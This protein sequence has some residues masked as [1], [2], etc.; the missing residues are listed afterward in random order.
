M[1]DQKFSI[2]VEVDASRAAAGLNQAKTAAQQTAQVFRTTSVEAKKI[3][4]AMNGPSFANKNFLT[5]AQG[6]HLR[7]QARAM[8]DMTSAVGA[9]GSAFKS[10]NGVDLSGG[11]QKA[12][13]AFR[14]MSQAMKAVP[15]MSDGMR[16]ALSEQVAVMKEYAA[17]SKTIAST[18][19][20]LGKAASAPAAIAAGTRATS[21]GLQEQAAAAT[22]A[23]AQ[24]QRYTG[25]LVDSL[26][27]MQ[28]VRNTLTALAASFGAYSVAVIGAAA[29]QERAFADVDRVLSAGSGTSRA[30]IEGLK[31]EY[32]QMATEFSTSFEDLTKI[33]T[34]G[35]QMNIAESDLKDFTQAVAEFAVVTGVSVDES[36][37]KM[38]RLVQFFNQAK[39]NDAGYQIRGA[40]D[41]SQYRQLASQIAEL[42]ASAV[43]TE[44]DILKMSE[45]IVTSTSNAGIGQDATLAYATT[46]TSTGIQAENARGAFQRLFKGFNSA[47][48]EGAIGMSDLAEQLNI[49]SEAAV[50]LW[51][52]D[53]NEFFMRLLKSLHEMDSISRSTAL[54][55]LGIKN[56]R[57]V[58]VVARL[59]QNYDLL[60]NSMSKAQSAGQDTS[61]LDESISII[62]STLTETI[63]RAK[64][65]L[66]NLGASLGEPFLN[67]IKS[68]L[69]AFTQAVQWVSTAFD[70]SWGRVV[71]S[72]A[73]GVTMA[74]ALRLGMAALKAAVVA[75]GHAFLNMKTTV[76][77]MGLSTKASW[78][79]IIGLLRTA[80]AETNNL[81]ATT[82]RLAP[83]TAKAANIQRSLE[84]A[85]S[86]GAASSAAS[87]ASSAAAG[88]SSAAA[89]AERATAALSRTSAAA[90]GA[91]TSMGLLGRASGAVGGVLS[92]IA[93]MGPWGWVTVGI[94]ALSAAIPLIQEYADANKHAAEEA[95]NRAKE[96]AS[97]L[98]SA[99]DVQKAIL[100]DA[101]A[102]AETGEGT[103]VKIPVEGFD[104][105]DSA[106]QKSGEVMYW[107]I[108]ASGQMVQ[109]TEKQAEA[110]GLAATAIGDNTKQLMLNAVQNSEA[111]KELSAKQRDWLTSGDFDLK[112]YFNAAAQGTDAADEFLNAYR[113]KLD[114]ELAATQ[115]TTINPNGTSTT[116]VDPK[117]EAQINAKKEALDSLSSS[118]GGV[119]DALSLLMGQMA[120]TEAAAEGMG[121]ATE[122]A[123]AATDDA[124]EGAKTAAEAY[125]E[126]RQALQDATSAAFAEIDAT[127]AL[128]ASLDS[129]SASI[130][131][132]GTTLDLATEAGRSN[133]A[134]I[135]EFVQQ[136]IALA[137]QQAESLG[138]VGAEAQKYV[139]DQVQTAMDYLS[140]QGFD[141]SQIDDAMNNVQAS[142]NA[143]LQGPTADYT[144][145]SNSMDQAIAMAQK[146][147]QI[148]ANIV[149]SSQ[150]A[151]NGMGGSTGTLRKGTTTT[152]GAKTGGTFKVP[153]NLVKVSTG[154]SSAAGAL[155][156]R[157]A[158]TSSSGRAATTA[159]AKSL[160]N[161]LKNYRYQPK[162][163]SRGGGGG[164][165][166]GS[167]T[168][169]STGG[170]GGGGGSRS[171]QKQK[172]AQEIF[173]D[174]LQRLAKA[175]KDSLDKFWKQIDAQD[176]YHSSLNSLTKKVQ[177]A[178]DRMNDLARDISDLSATLGE[179]QQK[180]RD[181]QYFN[182]VARKY[183]D[184]Q[185]IQSTQTDIDS[186][187][188]DI[189]KTQQS[190][191]DKQK[192]IATTQQSM[193]VL[194]GYTD[195][196]IENR[197]ALRDLQSAS[198]EM[199]EAYAAQGHSTNEIAAYTQQLKQRFIEQA[200]QLGFN[201]SEVRELAKAFDGFST[202]VRNVP[203]KVDVDVSDRGS[204]GRTQ[205]AI[206]GIRGGS[207]AITPWANTADA[208]NRI[209]WAARD[210]H[211]TVYASVAGSGLALGL[212][213][214]AR[215]WQ[216]GPIR[217]FAAGGLVPGRPPANRTKDNLTAVT[218]HG[219][220]YGIRSGEYVMSQRAVEHYGRGVMEAINSTRMPV[221]PS[222]SRVQGG[223]IQIDPNQIA[224]LARA[225][226][227]VITLDGKAISDST[228]NQWAVSGKRGLY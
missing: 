77:D 141:T 113:T 29:A 21:V 31:D 19:A 51:K 165:G 65:A 101:K 173:E 184:T 17:L 82:N 163:S 16:K 186:A 96:T 117:L 62:N 22:Q 81:V 59:S 50:D 134:A 85:R 219:T 132:N 227:S 142:L 89:G 78:I 94:T 90:T 175:L 122:D 153:T 67:P 150:G 206:N 2:D 136:T 11:A 121:I 228:S 166:G 88:V 154:I 220:V 118:S 4:D 6:E 147:A 223:P 53:P 208:E 102:Y 116:V 218:P 193:F 160:S 79:E 200:V 61:F 84:H 144:A 204:V 108:D 20:S 157:A 139:A 161:L 120:L 156:S 214:G 177:D 44:D 46:L 104:E 149:G 112:G 33:G 216:G 198:L 97:A 171:A 106:V 68:F 57:D 183:G 92:G 151:I 103:A 80:N 30:A 181:A 176:S 131:E 76:A 93:S 201:E 202:T 189:S 34:L 98:G 217:G 23:A 14:E 199:I 182:S 43:A 169:R 52:N 39:A 25:S 13:Q 226:S 24:N 222:P 15:L 129:L 5:K 128:Y 109:A 205:N 192:E 123:T 18:S 197:K 138:Y 37:E 196:A 195:A 210:R 63:A 75:T 146:K 143:P 209:N 95:Q 155:G 105:Y 191:A 74:V 58:E 190:I 124:A 3:F 212:A 187:Q 69:N 32:R 164:G 174:Y 225:V 40:D 114:A 140:Q 119:S 56:T 41:G 172:S 188:N 9:L 54:A 203:T 115:T 148:I 47:A 72:I 60:A 126:W 99:Q 135:E 64:N 87:S 12:S 194:K 27:G 224:A 211:M 207:P 35:T 48:A 178:R 130:A 91:A 8:K 70:S 10:L 45:S 213:M 145:L 125:D 159:A 26:A 71:A 162:Q 170:G 167:R 110:Q 28:Q 83:A 215:R 137:T 152:K 100:A 107:W 66:Q 168:P 55:D 7:A 38:G 133:M 180:L 1:A 158:T 73:G 221:A 86:Y 127:S 36:A 42:G 49:T 179:Q 111:F 185:R